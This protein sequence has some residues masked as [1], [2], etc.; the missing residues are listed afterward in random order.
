MKDCNQ[1]QPLPSNTIWDDKRRIGDDQFTCSEDAAGTSHL[2]LR[3]KEFD[4]LKNPLRYRCSVLRGIYGDIFVESAKV[5]DRSARPN[6]LHR[7]AL[8]SDALPQDFSHL[9]TFS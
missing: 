3:G 8:P 2:R 1:L 7:G 4:P 5:A 6:H 9:A